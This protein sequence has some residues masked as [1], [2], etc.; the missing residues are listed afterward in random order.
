MLIAHGSHVHNVHLIQLNMKRLDNIG[1]AK[2]RH[3][4]LT[5]QSIQLLKN[6]ALNN[7]YSI[8]NFYYNSIKMNIRNVFKDCNYSE[9]SL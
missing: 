9:T 1:A 6:D 2:P 4:K 3:A 5:L 7:N 8:C